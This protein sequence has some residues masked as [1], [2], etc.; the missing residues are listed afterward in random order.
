MRA[1][2]VEAF[3]ERPR[4]ASVADPTAVEGGVVSG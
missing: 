3:S 4:V 1:V 2:L